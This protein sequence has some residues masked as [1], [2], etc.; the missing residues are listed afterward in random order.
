MHAREHIYIYAKINRIGP[1]TVER[2]IPASVSQ[3][4]FMECH[5]L[6]S[7]DRKTPLPRHI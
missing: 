3:F 6:T 4:I 2:I 5:P 7:C 1:L